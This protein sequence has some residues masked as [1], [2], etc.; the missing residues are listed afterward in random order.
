M[1]DRTINDPPAINPTTPDPLLPPPR[2]A[3]PLTRHRPDPLYSVRS[4]W[5]RTGPIRN[6]PSPVEMRK[7]HIVLVSFTT[8][9]YASWPGLP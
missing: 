6:E 5:V 9:T 3:P 4:R 1:Q 7:L 2:A 8:K